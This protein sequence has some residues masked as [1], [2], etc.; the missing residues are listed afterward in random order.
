MI[1]SS[2]LPNSDFEDHVPLKS[3]RFIGFGNEEWKQR[4]Q[5]IRESSELSIV[6][7]ESG[8]LGIHIYLDGAGSPLHS[9]TD[10][11][12][13]P[14]E[15]LTAQLQAKLEQAVFFGGN[16][17]NPISFDLAHYDGGDL[18]LASLNV[19]KEILNSHSTL[20]N[21]NKDLTARLQERYRRIRSIIESIQ[22]AEMASRLSIDTRF[23]LSWSAEKLAAANTLW[24][25]YQQRMGGK[26][27]NKLSRANLKGVM[28][29][30]AARSLEI[31]GTQTKEDPV[32]FFLKYHVREGAFSLLHW[33]E[34]I[35]GSG[36]R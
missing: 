19:S 1:I 12:R 33:L 7:K 2:T 28:D 18:N 36:C 30:A 21:S 31:L 34:S 11:S 15:L 20:L 5:E 9:A 24:I 22:A 32:S 8:R 4:G 10:D 35:T 16:R 25:Q 14:Q 13:T 26:N 17:R 27:T 23:Q 6:C 3:D 29:D